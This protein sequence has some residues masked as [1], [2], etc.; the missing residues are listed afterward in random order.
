[1]DSSLSVE[2]VKVAGG[3]QAVPWPTGVGGNN[4][5]TPS[6]PDADDIMGAMHAWYPLGVRA[7]LQT[8]YSSQPN[9]PLFAIEVTPY[10]ASPYLDSPIEFCHMPPIF[11]LK[12]F[13]NGIFRT[14]NA[15]AGYGTPT[16]NLTCVCYQE[17][18]WP[19]RFLRCFR[20]ATYDMQYHIRVTSNF[21]TSGYLRAFIYTHGD[22]VLY[23]PIL[24][25]ALEAPNGTLPTV[26][27]GM[28]AISPL[29]SDRIGLLGYSNRVSE[30]IG[31]V[32]S[33]TSMVR[34]IEVEVPYRNLSSWT[35]RCQQY[36]QYGKNLFATANTA[37]GS[38][39]PPGK[40]TSVYNSS[41]GTNQV[42][43]FIIIESIGTLQSGTDSPITFDV[44]VRFKSF[45][46]HHYLGTSWKQLMCNA[47]T[48]QYV[49]N[50][51]MSGLVGQT[52]AYN[53]YAGDFMSNN[54]FPFIYP[55]PRLSLPSGVY[56]R[57]DRLSADFT[58]PVPAPAARIKRDAVTEQYPLSMLKFYIDHVNMRHRTMA[59]I[60]PGVAEALKVY[61]KM[62][63]HGMDITSAHF[64]LG[65][66]AVDIV[67]HTKHKKTK[68]KDEK[69][70]PTVLPELFSNPKFQEAK[71]RWPTVTDGAVESLHKEASA[72]SSS[73]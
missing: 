8:P 72:S 27:M 31:Y 54:M 60:S 10:V 20:G 16:Y 71:E 21:G 39:Y 44:E 33:D 57:W 29:Y 1:M 23:D 59:S 30:P 9:E 37:T 67:P 46:G 7:V 35:D 3:T 19:F 62:R 11:P 34:H 17:P 65:S 18:P 48:A 24:W 68:D 5:F 70:L 66:G 25:S 55:D 6:T 42:R 38:K 49:H 15:S 22:H 2:H 52:T 64:L 50:M 4:N 61:Y 63:F 32:R 51:Y 47:Q 28:C 56:P 36:G 45:E 41:R 58:P 12:N 69:P 40:N 73:A 43:T 53:N 14:D 26:P 13:G